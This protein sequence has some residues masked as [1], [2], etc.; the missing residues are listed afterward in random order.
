MEAFA[1]ISRFT[2]TFLTVTALAAGSLALLGCSPVDGETETVTL[3]LYFISAGEN[4]IA[5]MREVSVAADGELAVVAME[6]LLAGPTAQEVETQPALSTGIPEGTELLGVTVEDGIAKVDL[7]SEY[8]EGAGGFNIISRVGQVVYTLTDLEDVD[9]VDFYIEG[10]QAGVFS[11]E[12]LDL[13]E[14]QT[15]E[16]WEGSLPIDA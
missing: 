7:S 11:S 5:V 13:T 2:S 16:M 9:S 10:E 3:D 1:R 12:G 15:A 14:P 8:E 6:E 4:A